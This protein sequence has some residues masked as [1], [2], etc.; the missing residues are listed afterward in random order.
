MKKSN[1]SKQVKDLASAGYCSK[2]MLQ[3]KVL[4][5]YY[6]DLEKP[7]LNEQLE[8]DRLNLF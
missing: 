1:T 5:E 4:E 7:T 3:R 8:H 2:D 6:I